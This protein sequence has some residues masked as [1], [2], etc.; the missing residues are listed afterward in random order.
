MRNA[1]RLLLSTYQA[2]RVT[3]Y[4]ASGTGRKGLLLAKTYADFTAS[5]ALIMIY[6][7][8]YAIRYIPLPL[9]RE[10]LDKMEYRLYYI[11]R[12]HYIEGGR[13]GPRL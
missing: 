12:R 3:Y 10:A 2:A 9:Y 4:V 13:Y 5:L 8:S 1:Y 11:D 6:S 7:L